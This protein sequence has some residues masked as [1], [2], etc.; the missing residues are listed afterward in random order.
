M[1]FKELLTRYR[2]DYTPPEKL[3]A[4]DPGQTTGY[5]VFLDGELFEYGIIPW[6]E[7]RGW[8]LIVD[9]IHIVNPNVIVVEDYRLY[10]SKSS[11]QI[12]SQLNTVRIIGA[13]DFIAYRYNWKLV[14]QM[15]VTAKGFCTDYKLMEWGYWTGINRHARDS[16]RHGCYYLLFGDKS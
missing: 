7:T 4:I 5:S 14:K 3:L 10:A 11:A 1:K 16:I 2:P 8:D 12:G 15:A 13:I 9:K 6:T